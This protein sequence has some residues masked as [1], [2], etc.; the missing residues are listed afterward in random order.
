[1]SNCLANCS[2]TCISAGVT[3]LITFIR[4]VFQKT[5]GI[6]DTV[7]LE[8]AFNTFKCTL[9]PNI[10]NRITLLIRQI[11]TET[12]TLVK[13]VLIFSVLIIFLT[14]L[15][16]TLFVYLTIYIFTP[17]AMVGFFIGSIIIIIIA[18]LL[19]YFGV[20]HIY[21]TGSSSINNHLIDIENLLLSIECAANNGLCCLAS[22]TGTPGCSG[23]VICPP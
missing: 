12:S 6:D 23:C 9:P 16:L 5:I 20:L 7:R 21:D 3:Q 14:M 11:T 22:N 10:R 13:D 1:M 8:L 2:P 4:T 15:L 18:V 19:L 17:G